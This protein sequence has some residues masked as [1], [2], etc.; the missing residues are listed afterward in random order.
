MYVPKKSIWDVDSN[1]NYEKVT[2]YIN[3]KTKK[4]INNKKRSFKYKTT[5]Y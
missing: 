2:E 3:K 5:F 4:N 1:N